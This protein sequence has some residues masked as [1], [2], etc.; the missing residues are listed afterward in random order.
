MLSKPG[1]DEQEEL[2][3]RQK[4]QRGDKFRGHFASVAHTGVVLTNF[5]I[6]PHLYSCRNISSNERSTYLVYATMI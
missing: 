3:L 6:V 1:E 4:G 5:T 2:N